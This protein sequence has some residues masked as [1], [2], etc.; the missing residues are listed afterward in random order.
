MAMMFAGTGFFVYKNYSLTVK[1]KPAE[2]N[3][4]LSIGNFK[5]SNI[6]K[7]K[8]EIKDNKNDKISDIDIFNDPKFRALQD[9]SISQTPKVNIGRE[10]PF[11]PY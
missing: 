1:N 11:E 3:N 9:N 4:I 2:F 8:P 7:E 6:N 10:N 5:Q